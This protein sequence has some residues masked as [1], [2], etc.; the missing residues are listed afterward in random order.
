MHTPEADDKNIDQSED[1]THRLNCLRKA[2]EV[3]RRVI[4]NT[5]TL[6][7]FVKARMLMRSKLQPGVDL[8]DF[9]YFVNVIYKTFQK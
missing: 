9:W 2:A 6:K 1:F 5:K 3:H 7:C 8:H 4:M